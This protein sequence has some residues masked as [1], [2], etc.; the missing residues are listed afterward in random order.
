M[1]RLSLLDQSDGRADLR[2]LRLDNGS[3]WVRL[4]RLGVDADLGINIPPGQPSAT[5]LG[6]DVSDVAD[7]DRA[8]VAVAYQSPPYRVEVLR[9]PAAPAPAGP[10]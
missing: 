6:R 5:D 9:L 2:E 3:T 1:P 4:L 7:I 10:D 8:L